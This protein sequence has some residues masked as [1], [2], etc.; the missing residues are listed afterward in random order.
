[1]TSNSY[2][3][4]RRANFDCRLRSFFGQIGKHIAPLE[5]KDI[6][7][8]EVKHIEP[9]RHKTEFP[10]IRHSY[11]HSLSQLRS[12]QYRSTTLTTGT[13]ASHDDIL[14]A[15]PLAEE[16]WQTRR[17]MM[18]GRTFPIKTCFDI[19]IAGQS[20][21]TGGSMRHCTHNTPIALAPT[22]IRMHMPLSFRQGHRLGT[23]T[24]T[25]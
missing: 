21:R 5:V 6:D 22:I 2:S 1:M 13:Y 25:S 11:P 9:Q 15:L 12:K 19:R 14:V 4:S 18:I 7:D 16:Q 8:G 24:E 20:K 17:A 23:I 3:S 10:P